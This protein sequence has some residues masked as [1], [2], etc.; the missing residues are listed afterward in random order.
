MLLLI[1]FALYF[2][3]MRQTARLAVGLEPVPSFVVTVLP[4]VLMVFAAALS[5]SLLAPLIPPT[6]PLPT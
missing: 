3:S 1:P 2:T 5:Q 4:F 6:M